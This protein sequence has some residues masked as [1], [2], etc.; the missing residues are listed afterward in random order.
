M[1]REQLIRQ[2]KKILN[3]AGNSIAPIGTPVRIE[4]SIEVSGGKIL[5]FEIQLKNQVL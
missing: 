5:N 1:S 3:R 2:L 4:N